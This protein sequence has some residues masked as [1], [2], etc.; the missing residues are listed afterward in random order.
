MESQG[1]PKGKQ[2]E[3]EGGTLYS[4]WMVVRGWKLGREEFQTEEP[5]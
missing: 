5:V 4:P 1:R 2:N 3:E